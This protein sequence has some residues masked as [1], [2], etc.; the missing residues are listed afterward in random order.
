MLIIPS[1]SLEIVNLSIL[2]GSYSS[3]NLHLEY[4]LLRRRRHGDSQIH[5]D[6]SDGKGQGSS[7]VGDLYLDPLGQF[8]KSADNGTNIDR[9]GDDTQIWNYGDRC[10]LDRLDGNGI[11]GV[12]GHPGRYGVLAL[13]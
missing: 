13:S 12:A 6:L 10:N 9:L 3:F 7:G 2:S 5:G 8:C 4:R 11:L 1:A